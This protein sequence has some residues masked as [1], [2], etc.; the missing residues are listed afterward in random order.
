[1]RNCSLRSSRAPSGGSSPAAGPA[2]RAANRRPGGMT[3]SL[4]F[5]TAGESHG[6]GL[7]AIVEGM[8]AGV[9]L[10]ADQITY[11]LRRRH[12]CYGR[13]KRQQIEQDTVEILGG[14][15]DGRTLGSPIAM[16]VRNKDWP[17]W[18]NIM[19][20]GPIT[21]PGKRTLTRPRP[22]HADLA[23]GLKYGHEDLRNVL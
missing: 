18:E 22:G 10:T 8:P 14:V 19:S 12:L 2:Y 6:P 16:L 20:V 9:P 13:G 17:N 15:R 21:E 3:M 1:M 23:G 4:R 5:L 7:T 11:Q